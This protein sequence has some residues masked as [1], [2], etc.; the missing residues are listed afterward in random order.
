MNEILMTV[1]SAAIV[2]NFVFYRFLGICPF[3][4]VS[5]S[6]RSAVGMSIAVIL[7]MMVASA[8]T[9]AIN[10]HILVAH[11]LSYLRI[12]IFILVIASLVQFIEIYMKKTY[13]GLH[14]SFGIFLPL[15]T[16]NCAILGLVLLNALNE[17]GFVHTLAFSL[18]AGLGFLIAMVIMSGIR[19]RLEVAEIP[20]AMRGVPI[21]LIIAGILAMAFSAFSAI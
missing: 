8:V 16:T 2:N 10:T 18:G 12:L 3:I 15:I 4:G 1:F 21:V 6:T 7:V 20:Y 17:S 9:W 5:K 11:G 19:E 13:P 14:K